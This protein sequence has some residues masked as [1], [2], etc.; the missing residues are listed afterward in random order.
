[1]LVP[2]SFTEDSDPE[3]VLKTSAE[4]NLKQ[5][6]HEL[7]KQTL[8]QESSTNNLVL[9]NVQKTTEKN[10]LEVTKFV[11]DDHLFTFDNDLKILYF[12]NKEVITAHLKLVRQNYFDVVGLETDE[13]FLG[14]SLLAWGFEDCNKVAKR[15]FD[16]YHRITIVIRFLNIVNDI[17]K[18][19]KLNSKKMKVQSSN[20]LIDVNA[21]MKSISSSYPLKNVLL[22]LSDL[23]KVV[24]EEYSP[25]NY[26]ALVLIF[27]GLK[28]S[29]NIENSELSNLKKIDLDE[30]HSVIHVKGEYARDIRIPMEHMR[31]LVAASQQKI[32][33]RPRMGNFDKLMVADTPYV[34]RAIKSGTTKTHGPVSN[35]LIITR[36]DHIFADN[37]PLLGHVKPTYTA[38]RLA[39]KMQS[40]AR[41]VLGPK[42]DGP[43]NPDNDLLKKAVYE[44]LV[45]FGDL[46]QRDVDNHTQEAMEKMSRFKKQ[47]KTYYKD[48]FTSA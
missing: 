33:L 17:K 21:I 3:N 9:Y 24:R 47:F 6:M 26:A 43:K 10:D 36:N 37:A 44:T 12:A 2:I 18:Y 1:M 4:K 29:E 38:T 27:F 48:M 32:A 5:H 19:V 15:L 25:Q 41:K 46:H 20:E 22:T 7:L 45:T 42:L 23:G 39:G 30:I 16:K 13:K 11:D 35:T 8:A 14:K 28:R 34:L 31:A 40:I